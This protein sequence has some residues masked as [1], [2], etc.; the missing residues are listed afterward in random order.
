MTGEPDSNEGR[1]PPTIELKAT[2]VQDRDHD[3][4]AAS[5]A[6]AASG[7]AATP[8]NSGPA[9]TSPPPSRN[10]GRL[11]SHAVSAT[12]GAVLTAAVVVGLWFAGIIPRHAATAP[13][14]SDSNGA[15]EP[16]TP[17]DRTGPFR[18]PR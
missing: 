4:A 9:D 11:A 14:A 18:S 7:D 17:G 1:T 8:P 3:P 13:A 5:D 10:A 2:E 15:T 12:L 16:S 6:D